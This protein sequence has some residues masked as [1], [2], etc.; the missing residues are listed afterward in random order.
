MVDRIS[1]A[2]VILPS[3]ERMYRSDAIQACDVWWYNN[4]MLDLPFYAGKRTIKDRW[5]SALLDIVWERIDELPEEPA[6]KRLPTMIGCLDIMAGDHENVFLAVDAWVSYPRNGFVFD[7]FELVAKGAGIRLDD[8]RDGYRLALTKTGRAKS[9]GAMRDAILRAIG[10]VKRHEL[11]GREAKEAL[12][13]F[14]HGEYTEVVWPG[15][16]PVEWAM[17]VWKQ[18]SQVA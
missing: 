12:L 6:G 2:G 16:L 4:V 8:F 5:R 10:T 17:A 9:V 14:R 11:H 13:R 1:A 7:A 3:A 18:D 15:P